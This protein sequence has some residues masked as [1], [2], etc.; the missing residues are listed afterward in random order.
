MPDHGDEGVGLDAE[1]DAPEGVVA[2]AWEPIASAAEHDGQRAR[3][4]GVGCN[5]LA[6]SGEGRVEAP[7]GRVGDAPAHEHGEHEEDELGDG[8]RDPPVVDHPAHGLVAP[9]RHPVEAE[10]PGEL[11]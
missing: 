8:H 2:G 1:V 9:M 3:L 7:Q 6:G 5:V 10:S 11:A 4:G